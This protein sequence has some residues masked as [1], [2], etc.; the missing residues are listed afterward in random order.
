MNGGRKGGE[1]WAPGKDHE[2]SQGYGRG[3]VR[4]Y[5][6]IFSEH[7]EQF[8]CTTHGASVSWDGILE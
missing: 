7:L 1:G 4:S 8:V 6:S 3:Q 2:R 5:V